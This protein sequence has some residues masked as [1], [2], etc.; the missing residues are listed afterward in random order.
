MS[1]QNMVERLRKAVPLFEHGKSVGQTRIYENQRREA[2][3]RIEQLERERDEQAVLLENATENAAKYLNDWQAALQR[4]EQS[5]LALAEA[6]RGWVVCEMEQ[7][8]HAQYSTS[9][10]SRATEIQIVVRDP[11]LM[12]DPKNPN[13]AHWRYFM[14]PPFDAAISGNQP[15]TG[16]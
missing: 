4:A 6:R 5:D 2:A 9:A 13:Y 11:A 12:G 7:I 16:D 10:P 1:E 3:E 15:H 14:V 8:P